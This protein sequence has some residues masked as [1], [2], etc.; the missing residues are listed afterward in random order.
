MSITGLDSTRIIVIQ[1]GKHLVK[2]SKNG[3]HILSF[4]LSLS[5]FE[6]RFI[7]EKSE[8]KGHVGRII[9]I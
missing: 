6:C 8:E 7:D 4:P 3:Q 2:S 9:S 5:L 1:V